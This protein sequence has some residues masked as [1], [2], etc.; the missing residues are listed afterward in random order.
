MIGS[1]N[2]DEDAPR[3][4]AE[5]ATLLATGL[6]RLQ[7]RKSSRIV[8]ERGESSLHFS[9]AESGDPARLGRENRE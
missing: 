8:P 5:I 4:V 2:I 9:A 3:R 1:E 7:A 6:M